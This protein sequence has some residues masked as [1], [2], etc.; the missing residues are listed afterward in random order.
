MLQ[1]IAIRNFAIIDD[2]RISFSGG[3]TILSGETG[4][5]KSIIINAVNLLLGSR[6]SSK[7]IR[8][9]E[10]FAE[11]EALF[12][13]KPGS[14]VSKV[15]L[16][17]GFEAAEDLVLRR[18]IS[19]KDRHKIYVNGRL[20]TIQVLTA[21]TENLAS[22]SGQHEHQGLLKEDQH[23][24]ILDQFAG[25]MQL[26]AKVYRSFH[27]IVPLIQSLKALKASKQRQAEHAALL[28]FQ[29]KEISEAAF[30]PGEDA[31]L[32][33]EKARLKNIEMLYSTVHNGIEEL[34]G[35]QGSISDRLAAAK[36]D[37]D[38]AC[39]ID[40]DLAPLAGDIAALSFRLEDI[41]GAMRS[42]LSGLQID[43]GRLE[44]VEERLDFL[45]RLK[46]KYGGSLDVV[47]ARLQTIE[48]ELSEAEH[49]ADRIAETEQAI[50]VKYT[51]L[52]SSAEK[53]SEK[54][55]IA[56][57]FLAEEME[58]ELSG[59]R[60]PETKFKIR[61]Q[62]VPAEK[63]TD[64]QLMSDGKAILETGMDRAAFLISPNVG[65]ELKPLAFIASGGELS[66]IVLALKAILA[67]TES[68]ETLIFDEVD[69][70]IGGGTAEVV[71]K[72]L[73]SLAKYHQIICITHLPQIAKYG[74]QHYK[75][76]KHVLNGRTTTKIHPLEKDDRVE[77]IARMLGG[78]KI[79]RATREHAVEIMKS[80]P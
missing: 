13:V 78:D 71:G 6:A 34:Y 30:I 80:S 41:T 40:T 20:S 25:L 47:A 65:E 72:K 36:K 49:L 50:S 21:L 58:K 33:R 59:L 29:I 69:A 1:E 28:E 63:H 18:V 11:L 9:G 64:P 10:S 79:T 17:Q 39:E 19:N 55:N 4:A 14:S 73:S 45:N 62:S 56:S 27:E 35:A 54:R 16:D 22:I 48:R 61:V 23:L 5:G 7:L 68:T 66:R 77:E 2:L 42:Y 75:I 74:N 32:E 24:L 8:S 67:V 37:L 53:L 70:G 38:K 76:T 26:R 46:R 43:D 57:A 51:A 60:M 31:D 12:H 44:V 3:L 52:V 15:L